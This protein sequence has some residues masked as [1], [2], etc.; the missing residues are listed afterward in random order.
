MLRLTGHQSDADLD[1]FCSS[2][3]FERD[4]GIASGLG[5]AIGNWQSSIGNRPA[6]WRHLDVNVLVDPL[7]PGPNLRATR[8]LA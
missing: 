3:L 1:A 5:L 2:N 7:P 8:L 6:A 4:G